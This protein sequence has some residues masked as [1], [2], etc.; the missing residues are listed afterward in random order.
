[1]LMMMITRFGDGNHI[2]F[3]HVTSDSSN[4]HVVLLM[5]CFFIKTHL[6]HHTDTPIGIYD[7]HVT[8]HLICLA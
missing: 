4:S 6:D 7:M 5:I 3:F 2:P 1:M 8:L